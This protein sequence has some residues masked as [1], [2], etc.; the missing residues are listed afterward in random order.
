MIAG[1]SGF[2]TLIQSRDG[3]ERE[4]A[5]TPVRR[6][7]GQDKP[8]DERCSG[9]HLQQSPRLALLTANTSRN[10]TSVQFD[11]WCVARIAPFSPRGTIRPS[12]STIKPN[13]TT[14]TA[15]ISQNNFASG[16]DKAKSVVLRNSKGWW[17][18]VLGYVTAK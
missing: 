8:D 17:P 13:S 12:E 16:V 4:R 2:F 15:A 1:L 11:R 5:L 7:R 10:F 6:P 3:P 18:L 9:R 14:A